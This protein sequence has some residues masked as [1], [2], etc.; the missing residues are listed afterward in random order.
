MELKC[1]CGTTWARLEGDVL[2]VESR[3]HGRKHSNV[4]SIARLT[5]LAREER[6]DGREAG[7]VAEEV[8]HTEGAGGASAHS[9][10]RG[11]RGAPQAGA[12][13][14]ARAGGQGL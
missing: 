7:A 14:E 9:S 8:R 4:I 5:E 1:K 11:R 3:H 2:V 10:P 12:D 6:G 13:L